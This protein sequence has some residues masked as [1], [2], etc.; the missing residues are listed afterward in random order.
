MR[1][2]SIPLPSSI[3]NSFM[4]VFQGLIKT[5]GHVWA[6]SRIKTFKENLLKEHSDPGMR[7]KLYPWFRK[8]T[9]GHLKGI[10]GKLRKMSF[11]GHLESILNLLQ[12]YTSIEQ[13]ILRSNQVD[14]II[15]SIEPEPKDSIFWHRAYSRIPA[16]SKYL[17]LTGWQGYLPTKPI[18]IFQVPPAPHQLMRLPEDLINLSLPEEKRGIDMKGIIRL[19]HQALGADFDDDYLKS[20]HGLIC[21]K[22]HF[23][24]NP[25]LKSR[26]FAVPN[27]IIQRALDPLKIQLM[28][29]LNDLPWDCTFRQSRADHVIRNSLARGS[30]VH[31]VDLTG[32]TDNFPW[33]FQKKVL[34]T[35]VSDNH[36]WLTPMKHLFIS[37]VETGTWKLNIPEI[38]PRPHCYVM[39]SKGQ[40]LGLGP[41]FP[42]FALSHGMLLYILNRYKWKDSF[43]VL[44][45][46]V[47]IL[48]DR[49]YHAYMK[50]LFNANI[51]H[52]PGKS[53]SSN[54][55]ATFAGKIFTPSRNFYVPKWGLITQENLLDVAAYWPY[56]KLYRRLKDKAL[57][58]WVLSLPEPYGRGRNPAGLSYDQRLTTNLVAKLLDK[59]PQEVD[60]KSTVS[61]QSI[62]TLPSDS[63]SFL[64]RSLR[65]SP[66]YR[67]S[68]SG[69]Q[70]LKIQG[71]VLD[72]FYTSGV[73]SFPSGWSPRKDVWKLGTLSYWK[74]IQN[75]LKSDC[76]E[77]T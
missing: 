27:L 13:T 55:I 48:D 37:A 50:Y 75:S 58:D 24:P 41:S 11:N 3:K 42:L 30:T 38:E 23:T 63:R 53:Y 65:L 9:R 64:R 14:E 17:G 62:E 69:R 2:S 34:N 7:E 33:Y 76:P 18:P 29:R 61:W 32:A 31:S 60:R 22:V 6:V 8:T 52:S 16:A 47:V 28:T 74:G 70:T 4:D 40:P 77:G 21:G 45:D 59:E 26:Y 12:A 36:H 44:G 49:L 35:L 67:W 5:N 66:D 39:W 68:R 10:F 43:F 25:G 57:I 19:Y 73:P 1:L 15:R 71:E 56:P 51:P 54:R 72:L 20:D 46:D